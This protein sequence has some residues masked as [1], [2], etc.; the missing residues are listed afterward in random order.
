LS[1]N[2]FLKDNLL[3][4]AVTGISIVINFVSQLVIA[5]YFGTSFQRDA[6]FIAFAIPAFINIVVTNSIVVTFL[7]A[8]INTRI[9][10]EQSVPNM[11]GTT[12]LFT[13]GL[14]VLL[15]AIL[16][17]MAN[18]LITLMA[19][20]FDEQQVK[21]T[22][23]ILQILVVGFA[24]QSLNNLIGVTFHARQ[25]FFIPSLQPVIIALGSVCFVI[26]FH[27]QL[28]IFSLAWGYTAGN[29]AHTIM[30]LFRFPKMTVTDVGKTIGERE[31]KKIFILATPL[32]L[33]GIV[34][35]SAP[36]IE[37][38]FASGLPAGSVS[39]LGYA[40]QLVLALTNLASN[41]ISTTVYPRLVQHWSE[42]NYNLLG[43]QLN[44]AIN[45]IFLIA[46]PVI[47][48]VVFFG[49]EI[50]GVFFERGAFT[51]SDTIALALTL[52]LMMGYF[53]FAS[54]GNILGK[55]LYC[56]G[57]TTIASAV[58][59]VE[60]IIYFGFSYFLSKQ[61]S[62]GGLAIALSFSTGFTVFVFFYVISRIVKG[63]QLGYAFGMFLK[64]ASSAVLAILPF[65][66]IRLMITIDP[67]ITV[68][69]L[70]PVYFLFF[71][72]LCFKIFRIPEIEVV[73]NAIGL[74]LLKVKSK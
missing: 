45:T 62:Y 61:F 27:R 46:A 63:Y 71:A 10:N 64:I 9:T 73:W 19:P 54:L 44:N 40:S 60:I 47:A 23:N 37:R 24:I 30:L 11:I 5:G 50:I 39:Y 70:I 34:T 29:A 69:A 74:I 15:F 51:H 67:W 41:S 38:H 43:L 68:F 59:I 20:T 12:L 14:T 49:E 33:S 6:Y 32:L 4:V 65:Y 22:A 26:L 7:P 42:K 8:I 48:S 3:L 31:F 72:Y 56:A 1:N 53:L 66:F 2:K 36:I 16:S 21:F 18:G 58:G 52:S 25:H 17:L 13:S 28:G 55:M 57:R 35:R